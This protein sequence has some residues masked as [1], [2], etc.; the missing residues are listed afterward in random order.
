MSFPENL[1]LDQ[2]TLINLEIGYNFGQRANYFL[3]EIRDT[4][5]LVTITIANENS[6]SLVYDYSARNQK[7]PAG[8]QNLSYNNI[9]TTT[10][11]SGP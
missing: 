11:R 4:K 8:M 6:G 1:N 10:A 2:H 5:S 3:Y 9:A 7:L